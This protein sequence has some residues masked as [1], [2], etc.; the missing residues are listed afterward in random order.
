MEHP[1]VVK[2]P[3]HPIG[4]TRV[5]H[6]HLE[7][8]AAEIASPADVGFKTRPNMRRERLDELVRIV[9]WRARVNAVEKALRSGG[10]HVI[11][12]NPVSQL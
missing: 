4:I 12:Q 8:L 2:V 3:L 7:R 11:M 10:G 5:P 6:E 1:L 9:P